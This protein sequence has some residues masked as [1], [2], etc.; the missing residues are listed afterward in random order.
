MGFVGFSSTPSEDID[1][2][3]IPIDG[4]SACCLEWTFIVCFDVPDIVQDFVEKLPSMERE[5]AEL[6]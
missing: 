4:L 6:L 2:K 5:S 1:N 3:C